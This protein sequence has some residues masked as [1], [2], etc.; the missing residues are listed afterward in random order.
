MMATLLPLLASE[1]GSHAVPAGVT[2][3]FCGLLTALILCLALDIIIIA[4]FLSYDFAGFRSTRGRRVFSISFKQGINCRLLDILM[5][6]KVRLTRTKANHIYP[7]R[8]HPANFD[9]YSQCCR[10]LQR[11]GAVGEM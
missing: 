3:L 9:R 11:L 10:C 7:L 1:A 6:I 5:S 8:F 4:E 2:Y